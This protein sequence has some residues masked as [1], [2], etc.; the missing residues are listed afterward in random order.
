MELDLTTQVTRKTSI[1]FLPSRADGFNKPEPVM[2]F[3]SFSKTEDIGWQINNLFNVSHFPQFNCVT[4]EETARSEY[5]T[6]NDIGRK[7]IGNE[8][9]DE[10]FYQ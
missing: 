10:A 7:R 4:R 1:Y 9:G 8:V 2:S 3:F 6:C 5:S